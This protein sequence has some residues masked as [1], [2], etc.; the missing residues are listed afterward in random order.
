[1][2]PRP[3]PPRLTHFLCLPLI[4]STSRPQLQ[5]SLATFRDKVTG[6]STPEL[7]N[8][9]PEKAIRPLGTLHLTLGVMSLLSQ[10]RIDNSLKHLRS[11]NLKELLSCASPKP[12]KTSD[13]AEDST[14][15]PQSKDK[16]IAFD[17]KD[18]EPLKVTLR[19]LES[20]HTPSNTSILY[21]S[22]T[23]DDRLYPFCQK[24]KDLF[25]EA[26]FI[27]EENR[28]LKLHATIVNTVYVPGARG[29][30][31][32][33]K[34]KAKLTLDAREILEDYE[35]FEWMSNVELTKLAICKMGAQKNGAGEE[36]YVVEGEVEMP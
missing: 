18:V 35:D 14:G 8:G 30:G 27:L 28:P 15:Q 17:T 32:H 33:G 22:P 11:L 10:E 25:T 12:L 19:G 3:S 4:T 7:P 5:N 24:L 26:G 16:A 6:I 20:M 21:S 29:K 34:S 23:S 2:P 31:G 9:V 36:E 1:M 13:V